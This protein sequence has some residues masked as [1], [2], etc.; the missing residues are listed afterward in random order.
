VSGF[1]VVTD[2]LVD[3]AGAVD[4]ATAELGSLDPATP[5]AEVPGA[6]PG[7]A[8]AAAAGDLAIRLTV[9]CQALAETLAEVAGAARGNASTYGSSDGRV[10]QHLTTV[11]GAP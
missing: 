4:G 5:M 7:T 3:F 10:S 2:A 9:A 1:D 6:V 11:G 8:T